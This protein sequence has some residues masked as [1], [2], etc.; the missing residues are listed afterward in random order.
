[1]PLT[2]YARAMADQR[3]TAAGLVKKIDLADPTTHMADFSGLG[4]SVG[5]TAFDVVVLAVPEGHGNVI[6]EFILA[7][8]GPS[9]IDVRD[10]RAPG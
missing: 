5:A 2:L 1:M 3:V 7:K 4:T 8:A 9:G 10:E 6:L